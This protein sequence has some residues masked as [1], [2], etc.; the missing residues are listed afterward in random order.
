MRSS[1]VSGRR[2]SFCCVPRGANHPRAAH[3]DLARADEGGTGGGRHR[4]KKRAEAGEP[5]DDGNSH[6]L[7]RLWAFATSPDGLGLTPERFWSLTIPEYN[8]LKEVHD[9]RVSGELRRWAIERAQFAN[10]HF[11]RVERG[12]YQDAPFVPE[13]FLGSGDHAKR[14][15]EM[16]QS[17]RAVAMETARLAKMRHGQK[18]NPAK[19]V[20]MPQ[21]R[22]GKVVYS[23]EGVPDIFRKLAEQ[24][25]AKKRG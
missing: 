10:V 7:L 1:S 9:N 8:A 17:R 4:N 24:H 2:G 23:G 25:E 11:R 20:E 16:M 21:I 5:G 3:R 18:F 6:R 14:T 15:A 12:Q 22:D 13:D 19:I